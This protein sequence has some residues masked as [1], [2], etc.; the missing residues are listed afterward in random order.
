MNAEEGLIANFY[1]GF[2]MY[3]IVVSIF[4]SVA[5]LAVLFRKKYFLS[6]DGS[7]YSKVVYY[8]LLSV[9]TLNISFFSYMSV[10]HFLD[11]S[12]VS[13]EHFEFYCGVPVAYEIET[14]DGGR[15]MTVFRAEDGSMKTF[16]VGETK[17]GVSYDIIYLKHTKLA[18]CKGETE[19]EEIPLVIL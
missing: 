4:I 16:S 5:V 17:K 7:V 9:I 3:F 6:K 13:Q 2:W 18:A 11:L 8:V 15:G 12:A 1:L 14:E 19:A 10:L